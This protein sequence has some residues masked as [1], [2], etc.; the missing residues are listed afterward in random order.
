MR[1]FQVGFK[2]PLSLIDS[3]LLDNGNDNHDYVISIIGRRNGINSLV[4]VEK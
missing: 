2:K 3:L 4:K 1:M